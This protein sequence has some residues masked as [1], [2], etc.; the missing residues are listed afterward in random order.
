[1]VASL[2]LDKS[3]LKFR[4]CSTL[5][6]TPLAADACRGYHEDKAKAGRAAVNATPKA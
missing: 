2:G 3:T 1:M 4:D 6:L 5:L